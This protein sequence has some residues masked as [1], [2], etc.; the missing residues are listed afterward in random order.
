MRKLVKMLERVGYRAPFNI[1]V[2][3]EF[4][5]LFNK[6]Q[7]PLSVIEK[8]LNGKIRLCTTTCEY[9]RYT[10]LISDK[11]LLGYVALKKCKHAGEFRTFECLSEIIE[12]NNPHHFFVGVGMKHRRIKEEKKIPVIFLRS[13]VLC[14]EVGKI[15]QEQ[16]KNREPEGLPKE[17]RE[18]LE[19]LFKEKK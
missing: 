9:K 14:M 5:S 19:E 18:R 13:G 17:E 10:S 15:E 7:M 11:T 12:E 3:H 4:L 1:L 6:S 16:F 8:F 2:D